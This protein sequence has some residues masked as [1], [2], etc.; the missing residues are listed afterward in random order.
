M[1]LHASTKCGNE[2][3]ADKYQGGIQLNGHLCCYW[4]LATSVCSF[5]ESSLHVCSAIRRVEPLVVLV[6]SVC[7]VDVCD[8]FVWWVSVVGECRVFV[9][10]VSAL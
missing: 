9:P 1:H 3:E 7:V 2:S 4:H 5:L 6:S 8:V 10:W